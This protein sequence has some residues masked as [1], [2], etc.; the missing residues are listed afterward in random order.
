MCVY[1]A[2]FFAE[3]TLAAQ[4][5]LSGSHSCNVLEHEHTGLSQ[6]IGEEGGNGQRPVSLAVHNAAANQSRTHHHHHNNN[7]NIPYPI[8]RNRQKDTHTPGPELLPPSHLTHP[9]SLFSL[10]SQAWATPPASRTSWPIHRTSAR[11]RRRKRTISDELVGRWT[12][13]FTERQWRPV[14]TYL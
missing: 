9:I 10:P 2:F 1:A 6:K 5:C 13:A 8:I 7:N 12:S 3:T 4:P 11:R 14:R